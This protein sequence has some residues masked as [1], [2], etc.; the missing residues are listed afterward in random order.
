[1]KILVLGDIHEQTANLE[2]LASE[3]EA[4]DLVVVHGDLTNGGGKE[5]ARD[6]LERI[7]AHGGDP[8]LAQPGNMDHREATDWFAEQG[9]DL[10]GRGRR[11]DDLA[12]LGVGGSNPTP[13]GTP[14]EFSEEEIERFLAAASGE[15]GDAAHT[16][17]VSHAPP[18]GTSIDLVGGDK[19]VGSEAVRRFIEEHRPAVC[20][21]GHIHEARG[22]DRIGETSVFNTGMLSAGGYVW[23][24]PG[25][26]G[27]RAELRTVGSDR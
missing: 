21:S 23:I 19:H 16:I 13:F 26:G 6:I 8:L 27:L 1:M 10:H 25:P 2:P 14:T 9:I 17:L 11:Y 4:A 3:L 5:R 18:R 15:A 12:I 7:R 20:V 22:E 24:E